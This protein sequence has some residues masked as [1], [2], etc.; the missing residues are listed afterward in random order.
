MG[1]ID[2]LTAGFDLVRKKLWLILIPV[3]L[4]LGLW[5]MPRLSIAGLVRDLLATLSA[6]LAPN[7]MPAN[8][9]EVAQL[10]QEL[11]E[12][13]D[14]G[15]L[16]AG[17]SV[18]PAYLGLPSLPPAGATTLFGLTREVIEIRGGLT[19]MGLAAGLFLA[20]LLWSALYL[21]ALAQQVRDGRADWGALL[22][23]LPRNWLRLLGAWLLIQVA[24]LVIGFPLIITLTLAAVV[25]GPFSLLIV[26]ALMFWVVIYAAF[27]PYAIFM[28]EDG[29]LQAVARSVN[30]V[31][32]N[33]R[34]T[35]ALIVL[36]FVIWFGLTLV[37]ARLTGTTIGALVAIAANAFVGTG[38]TAAIFIFYRERL[39]AWQAA[40]GAQRSRA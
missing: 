17:A 28:H 32:A 26:S 23:R 22:R 39:R 19:L 37:F 27:V 34:S 20:G 21:G 33:F 29:L 16:L 18:P 40:V 11:A 8:L 35:L 2:T 13:L 3:V 12:S 7:S 1:V 5:L 30:V 9:R 6:S 24:L 36:V 38:L 14:I 4:D 31:R 15:Q 10:W 25:L